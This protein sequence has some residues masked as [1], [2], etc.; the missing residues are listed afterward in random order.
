[1]GWIVPADRSKYATYWVTQKQADVKLGFAGPDADRRV[2]MTWNPRFNAWEP[3]SRRIFI[4]AVCLHSN[5]GWRL[6]E[7]AV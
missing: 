4:T 5:N 3:T 2:E 7:E 6:D 1:M